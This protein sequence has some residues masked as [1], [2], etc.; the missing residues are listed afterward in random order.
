[1][2]L[3]LEFRVIRILCEEQRARCTQT[4]IFLLIDHACVINTLA[5]LGNDRHIEV[6]F[7]DVNMSGISG[8]QLAARAKEIR[9]ELKIILLF[10]A[11]VDPHGW[12]LVRKPFLQSDLMRAMSDAV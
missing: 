9:P 8:Y 2:H 12:P 5:K 3:V 6:L 4:I 1:M 7:T 11:E 10:G